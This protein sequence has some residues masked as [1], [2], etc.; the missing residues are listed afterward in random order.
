[1]WNDAAY[2]SLN[3][4]RRFASDEDPSASRNGMLGEFLDRGY[5]ST[6]VLDICKITDNSPLSGPKAVIS[7]RRLIDDM[8]ENR[9]L[10]TRENFVSFDGLPYDYGAARDA[11]YSSL[12]PQEMLKPHWVPMKGPQGWGMSEIVQGAF[13]QL[14]GVER[15]HRRR[16]DIMSEKVFKTLSSWL[17]APIF[18]TLRTHR[19]KYIGHAADAVSRQVQPLSRLGISLNE[20]SEAQRIVIR[21]ANGIG[22]TVLYHHGIGSPVPTPQFDVFENLNLPLVPEKYMQELSEWWDKHEREREAWLRERIDFLSG[23]ISPY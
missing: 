8:A 4:A 18:D 17:D 16:D 2:R 5:L 14:S 20:I 11:Y 3:E 9:H 21:V 22:S 15:S 13:D 10:L 23:S 7:L 19:N 12:T 1:M 6:Q